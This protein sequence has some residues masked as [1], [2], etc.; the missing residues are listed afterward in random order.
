MFSCINLKNINKDTLFPKYLITFV[1]KIFNLVLEIKKTQQADLDSRRWIGFTIG[2]I[3]AISIFY[4][5]MEFS[6]SSI[7][8]NNDKI[9]IKKDLILNE[10]MIP[11]IDQQDIA[12]DLNKDKPTTNDR[13]R[14]KRS[15][16]P[17]KVTPH[18]VGSLK[19]NDPRTA[20]PRMTDIPII[21]NSKSDIPNF[22]KAVD[23]IAKKELN[24]FTDDKSDKKIERIDDKIHKKLLAQAPTPPG[25]WSD[26]MVWLTKNIKY[27]KSA[28]ENLKT[29]SLIVTFIIN[30]DGSVE[31]IRIKTPKNFE[32]DSEILKVVRKMGRWKSGKDKNQPCKSIIDIPIEF[33]L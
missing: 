16:S 18:D 21:V 10:D 6:S 2:I 11:A 19:T 12:K 28:K 13:L 1:Y 14:V 23:D 29:C 32:F 25:G 17:N 4:V 7:D 31:N 9:N 15:D 30:I 8:D 3:V 20:A 27:P 22:T 26:F 24:K 5:A 33:Q